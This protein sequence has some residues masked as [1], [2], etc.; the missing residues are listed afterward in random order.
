MNY[1]RIPTLILLAAWTCLAQQADRFA[2][3]ALEAP[4]PQRAR[5]AEKLPLKL[6]AI[7]LEASRTNPAVVFPRRHVMSTKAEFRTAVAE[8]K[9]KYQPFLEDRTPAGPVTRAKVSLDTFDFRMEEPA[10]LQDIGRVF[11]GEGKWDPVRIP[12]YRGPIGWWAGYY[13]KVLTIPD[14]I[15]KHEAVLEVDL[16]ENL[17]GLGRLPAGIYFLRVSLGGTAHTEKVVLFE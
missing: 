9:R 8:L 4:P 11:R 10:D 17:K 5:L 14:S 3:I 6:P 16:G 13:R 1:S 15:W 2:A 12:D 7:E